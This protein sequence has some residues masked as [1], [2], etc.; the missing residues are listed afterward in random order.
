M[1]N[2]STA[3]R[4]RVVPGHRAVVTTGAIGG[5]RADDSFAKGPVVI[6]GTPARTRTTRAFPRLDMVVRPVA[7]LLGPPMLFV[8]SLVLVNA[9]LTII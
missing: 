4:R 9:V 6:P 8:L 1:R 3:P 7:P 2:R 5:S